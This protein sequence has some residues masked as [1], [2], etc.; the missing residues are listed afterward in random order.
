MLWVSLAVLCCVH[1]RHTIHNRFC[2]SCNF[3]N[4]FSSVL[5]SLAL[6]AVCRL[7]VLL[8]RGRR[9]SAIILSVMLDDYDVLIDCLTTTVPRW[10][11]ISERFEARN[12]IWRSLEIS[13]LLFWHHSSFFYVYWV[14][15]RCHRLWWMLDFN[16]LHYN[17]FVCLR[18]SWENVTGKICCFRNFWIFTATTIFNEK[19]GIVEKSQERVG[20][21]DCIIGYCRL[22]K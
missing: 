22:K 5:C 15:Q 9:K 10:T 18:F 1:G 19:Q 21:F 12:D 2:F 11:R 13:F 8:R 16:W 3:V 14:T 6:C 17:A 7:W 4:D 20:I